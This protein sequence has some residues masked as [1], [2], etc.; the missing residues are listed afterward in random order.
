MLRTKIVARAL[1]R[2]IES[3]QKIDAAKYDSAMQRRTDLYATAHRADGIYA[4]TESVN[5][6]GV[7]YDSEKFT[8][9][10]AR[11]IESLRPQFLLLPE[12]TTALIEFSNP[13]ETSYGTRPNSYNGSAWLDEIGPFMPDFYYRT[14]EGGGLENRHFR[15]MPSPMPPGNLTCHIFPATTTPARG[16]FYDNT[17][18]RSG[19]RSIREQAF[20]SFMSV[21][22]SGG[23]IS[24]VL[25]ICPANNNPAGN[26]SRALGYAVNVKGFEEQDLP[27][28]LSH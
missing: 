14:L 9:L 20:N 2:A 3:Y 22:E 26:F 27:L 6:E 7:F 28:G 17:G 10:A 15:F 4:D 24:G 25:E 8:A 19:S 5:A 21:L 12:R 13:L 18:S 16:I 1:E 11:T 23:I